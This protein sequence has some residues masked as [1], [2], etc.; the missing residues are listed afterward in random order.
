MSSIPD[1]EYYRDLFLEIHKPCA[2]VDLNL[3]ERNIEAILGRARDKNVRIASKSIRCVAILQTLLSSSQQIKGMMCYTAKEAAFLASKGFDDL[4]VAYPVWHPEEIS[5]ACEQIERGSKIILM[6]DCIEH[7]QRIDSIASQHDVEVP[8]CLDIDMSTNHF[9]IHFGVYRSSVNTPQKA[10]DVC[11]VIQQK[12]H[13]F[14]DGVMGYEAQIAG[15]P[16]KSPA[17]NFLINFVI[18]RLKKKSKKIV[19]KRRSEIVNR[20]IKEGFDLRF[21][22]GGGTGSVE[23]TSEE[24]VITEVTVGSGFYSPTLFDYYDNFKHLPAAGFVLEITRKP[25][26]NVF[27]CHGGGYVAS[28]SA[29]IDKLPRPFLPRGAKLDSNEGA[30]EV[31]TPIIYKGP[32]S[33]NIGD[34]IFMR[35]AKAGEL[36]EHFNE[37]Y[38]VKD[39]KIREIVKTYRGEGQR[40]L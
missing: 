13:V 40:F 3:L 8:L 28:G 17:K 34:P 21:V 2:Y 35:H 32:F 33:L 12:S 39:S 36:C 1:Y 4:L 11:G 24:D 38:L 20:I 23:I 30:G 18:R 22:N 7:V 6:V 16:D 31:Q 9:G 29:G 14:L 10:I 5:A 27:T 25:E 15:L 37:L 26:P 19:R